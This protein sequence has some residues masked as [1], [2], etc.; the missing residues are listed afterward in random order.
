ML[1]LGVLDNGLVLLNIPAFYQYVAG[2]LLLVVAV[3]IQ[4]YRETAGGLIR[5]LRQRDQTSEPPVVP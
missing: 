5:N 1:L 3:M 2:G 4:E